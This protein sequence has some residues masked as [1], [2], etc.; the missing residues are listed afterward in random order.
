MTFLEECILYIFKVWT[1]P[2]IKKSEMHSFYFKMINYY[3]LHKLVIWGHT[4]KSYIFKKYE[5]I[6]NPVSVNINE[7]LEDQ[8]SDKKLDKKSNIKNETSGLINLLKSSINKNNENWVS[9]G[10]KTEFETNLNNSL[11]L[12][13][14]NYKKFI[15]QG[16]VNANLVPIGHFLN[17]VPKFYHPDTGW[18]ESPEYLNNEKKFVE[19]TIL[20]GYDERSSTGIQ[21]RFKIRNPIQNIKQFKDS[22]LIERGTVCSYKSKFYLYN[23]A[24]KFNIK[25]GK[26]NNITN[27][28]NLIRTKLIYLELKER[29]KDSNIKYFYF[30]Y[31][32]RP[33]T[34]LDN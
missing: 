28:C 30:I 8:I 14:G 5:K 20:I 17:L 22:R 1:D 27:L 15:K 18:I 12:F 19:N 7:I 3:D 29:E 21:I 31:E 9:T 24:K 25:L 26:K 32:Q 10:I 13:D 33:E 4:A 23:I 6:L 16:L 2:N 11:K 34:I